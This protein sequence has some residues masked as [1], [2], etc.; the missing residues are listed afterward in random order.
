MLKAVEEDK[1]D[2]SE[3]DEGKTGDAGHE[4]SGQADEHDDDDDDDRGG[5]TH[6]AIIARPGTKSFRA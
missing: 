2:E 3:P 6:A 4:R 1:G 5:E